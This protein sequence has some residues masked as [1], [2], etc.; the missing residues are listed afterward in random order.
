MAD[1]RRVHPPLLRHE[2]AARA[3][4]VGDVHQTERRRREDDEVLGQSGEVGAEQRHPEQKLN[5][6]TRVDSV[7]QR[8]G[9]G[10]I[11]P[12]Q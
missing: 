10:H 7:R 2:R 11:G 6:G 5:Y 9:G 3:V 1:V 8:S 4:G 12:E